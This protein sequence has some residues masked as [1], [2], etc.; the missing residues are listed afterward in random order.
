MRSKR[1]SEIAYGCW[2][3]SHIAYGLWHIVEGVK[4]TIRYK[5]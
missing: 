5:L 4:K 2:L 1:V 3:K